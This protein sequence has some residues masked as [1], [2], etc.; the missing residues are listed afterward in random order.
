M[1]GGLIRCHA[2]RMSECSGNIFFLF[3]YTCHTLHG[4]IN[5]LGYHGPH[6]ILQLSWLRKLNQSSLDIPIDGAWVL[7]TMGPRQNIWMD[8]TISEDDSNW[9]RSAFACQCSTSHELWSWW[10]F[11]HQ[12]YG[13]WKTNSSP[14]YTLIFHQQC[15]TPNFSSWKHWKHSCLWVGRAI[16]SLAYSL[17][18]EN[19]HALLGP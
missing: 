15:P 7:G 18:F 6:K 1:T 17:A 5:K 14:T 8:M 10:Q 13:G 19:I 16:I 9:V 12:N 2:R 3:L 4:L 11:C